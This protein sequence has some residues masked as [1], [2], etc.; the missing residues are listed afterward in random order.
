MKNKRKT[1]YW[2]P[3][4]G[5]VYNYPFSVRPCYVCNKKTIFKLDKHLKHS[6]CRKCKNPGISMFER[7]ILGIESQFNKTINSKVNK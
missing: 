4:D 3:K 6:V 1:I 7:R 2:K 5:K